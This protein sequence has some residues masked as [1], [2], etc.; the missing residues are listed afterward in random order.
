L[1]I[2]TMLRTAS[3]TQAARTTSAAPA[4]PAGATSF[5]A[6]LSSAQKRPTVAQFMA[7]TGASAREASRIIYQHK[8]WALYTSDASPPGVLDAQAQIKAETDSGVRAKSWTAAT[9]LTG[10]SVFAWRE[11]PEPTV[12][13]KIVPHYNDAGRLVGLG[14]IDGNGVRQTLGG[15]GDKASFERLALGVGVGRAGLDAFAQKLGFN[16][17]AGLDFKRLNVFMPTRHQWIARYGRTELW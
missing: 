8:D 16:D 11:P 10:A 17:F 6:A 15:T 2:N 1:A 9:D 3:V 7:L 12:P 13:G 14:F 4:T 5:A